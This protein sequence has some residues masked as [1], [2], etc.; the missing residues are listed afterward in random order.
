MPAPET[1]LEMTVHGLPPLQPGLAGAQRTRSGR[2][3]MLAVFAVCAAPVVASYFTYYVLRPGQQRSFGELIAAQP[4]LPSATATTLDGAPLPL[5]SLKG[6]WLLLSVAGGACGSACESH[7]YLQR[8]L[9]ETLGREKDRLDRV[10]LIS[11]DTPVPAHLRPAL[12]QA[13][14][15]RVPEAV[16][17]GW[18]QPAP[19]HALQ[20]HLYVVDPQGHWM[21]RMPAGLG[22]ADAGKA[23]RDLD[24]LLRASASW[25]TAG[26]PGD[27]E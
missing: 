4:A 27:G 22:M 25:D 5:Q 17:R 12:A 18:L 23:K 8:Q 15:L 6:Q 9:R 16:L 3:K 24:R 26:H 1:P 10:W 11:D 20:D 13:T 14:V 19:G 21:M 2:W 7:L